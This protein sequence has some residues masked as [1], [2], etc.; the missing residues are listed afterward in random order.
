MI[1][2][3]VIDRSLKLLWEICRS[4]RINRLIEAGKG[5]WLGGGGVGDGRQLLRH[6]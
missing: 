4:K 2:T 5:V 6:S 1:H 3:F